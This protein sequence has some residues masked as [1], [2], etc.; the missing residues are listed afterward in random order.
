M[1]G[2]V[3]L[4]QAG[5]KVLAETTEKT[6]SRLNEAISL[7]TGGQVSMAQPAPMPD[8]MPRLDA[9]AAS[10][11]EAKRKLDERPALDAS[12]RFDMAAAMLETIQNRLDQQLQQLGQ[13]S[14]ARDDTGIEMDEPLFVGS[15]LTEV[16][17][18][19][20]TTTQQIQQLRDQL[21]ALAGKPDG[22]G[23]SGEQMTNQWYQMAA[24]IEATRG[25]IEQTILQQ[26][27]KLEAKLGTAPNGKA[28][29]DP[30]AFT[31]S[32]QQM[33]QQTQI[34]AELVTTLSVLDAHMQQIKSE[35]GQHKA[36]A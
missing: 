7:I 23:M 29:V 28:S 18:G 15:F 4:L 26:M 17:M 10:L 3:N 13:K 5:G 32:Q 33:E 11:E 36:S 27:E 19:F 30:E 20:E 16:R 25:A 34:L 1:F 12:S 8:I 21:A 35:I 6:Q 2:A 14:A 24:Q 22:A 9:I 31:A